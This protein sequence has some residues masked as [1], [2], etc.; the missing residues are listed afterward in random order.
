MNIIE[1]AKEKV[2]KGIPLTEKEIIE[3]LEI[4]LGS[5][6]DKELR[7]VA[8]EIA[9]IKAN[10]T[11]YIWSAIGA[12]YVSCPMNCKFCSFGEDWKI[13]KKTVR[14]TTKELIDKA[15]YYIENGAR[16][17]VLRTTENTS[18]KICFHISKNLL[19]LVVVRLRH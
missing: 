14:Y 5:K 10:N 8:R 9:K 15:R 11:A 2:L 6:E 1:N 13:I 3:L 16:F 7:K 18:Y 12:D 17:V 19:L 4:P